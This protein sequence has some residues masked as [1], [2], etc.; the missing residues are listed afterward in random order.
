MGFIMLKGIYSVA[1]PLACILSTAFA[2]IGISAAQ[3]NDC[4]ACCQPVCE[5]QPCCNN[6]RGWF[7]DAAIFVGAAAVG[8]IAGVAAGNSSSRRG[9]TG[10]AGPTGL[11]GP[12]GPA[13]TAGT[14]GLGFTP[15]VVPPGQPDAGA[16]VTSMTFTFTT[17]VAIGV[18][19]PF[20]A[21][22]TTP[23]GRTVL[24]T[25]FNGILG[26]TA[27]V[28][29]PT[30]PFFTGQYNV[31]IIAPAALL[32][33]AG[34]VSA[35][36]TNINGNAVSPALDDVGIVVAATL[37]TTETFFNAQYPFENVP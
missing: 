23:D 26:S 27:T 34:V 36:V 24:G 9:R 20:Q 5:E 1:T 35:T 14:N 19:G 30:G 13:G 37:L 22:V 12:Q 10:E 18:L 15:A 4:N 8:A 7:R 25:T 17:L 31:G 6:N 28:T 33:L 3:Y 11:T 29:I 32:T 2:P 16:P 21:Y